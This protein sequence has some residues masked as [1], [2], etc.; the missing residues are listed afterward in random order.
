[1][2]RPTRHLVMLAAAS[3]AGGGFTAVAGGPVSSASAETGLGTTAEAGVLPIVRDGVSQDLGYCG[4]APL[5]E[6][7]SDVTDVVIAVHG[8][9]RGACSYARSA[10]EAAARAGKADRTLVIAPHFAASS[11]SEAALPQRLYWSSSGWKEG[12]DSLASPYPRAW[13]MSSFEAVDLLIKRAADRLLY[14]NVQRVV[15]AGHSA[16]GQFVN[17]YV[18]V[19]A[20]PPAATPDVVR[21]AVVANP[22]SYLYLDERRPDPKTGV[23]RTLSRKERSS[24]RSYDR[25]KYGLS[26]RSGYAGAL[27]PSSVIAQF[28]ATPV[29]YLAGSLDT[30]P[31]DSSL[32]TS[33]AGTWQG[34]Q[35]LD[36][37]Q[38]YQTH[39]NAVIGRSG[40]PFVVVPGVGHTA[41]G[42]F[43]SPEG[44]AA[45]FS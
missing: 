43:T 29:T 44:V 31:T 41:R 33:C 8:D 10:L 42:M 40:H 37:A 27:T 21:R 2:A 24:C 23:L 15:V 35:R 34:S 19:S 30:D 3:L 5:S 7:L 4:N 17:R 9:G 18:G 20:L 28:R 16:G 39:L 1:M 12:D 32:D 13:S 36:R 25:Y 14:P 38:K 11:D 22:S 45:L 26:E 6:T